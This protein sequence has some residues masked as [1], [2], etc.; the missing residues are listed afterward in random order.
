MCGERSRDI[1]CHLISVSIPPGS[2]YFIP[3]LEF[4]GFLAPPH[5]SLAGT[6]LFFLLN[7]FPFFG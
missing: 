6:I 1:D 7:S 2:N 3:G 5:C 4:Q